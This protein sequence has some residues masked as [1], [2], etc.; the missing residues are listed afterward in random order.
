M[1]NEIK[2]AV[3]NPQSGRY[4]LGVLYDFYNVI[5]RHRRQPAQNE[6]VN[7]LPVNLDAA[8]VDESYLESLARELPFRDIDR[9]GPMDLSLDELSK[10]SPTIAIEANG[11]IQNGLVVDMGGG[12]ATWGKY[13]VFYQ[14]RFNGDSH[15]LRVNHIFGN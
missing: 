4:Y 8:K 2:K 12:H 3:P 1:A 9:K 15:K 11:A 10:I 5:T 14:F 13:L 6:P 7:R